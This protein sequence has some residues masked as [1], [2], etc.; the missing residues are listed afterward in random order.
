M[1]KAQEFMEGKRCC[2]RH[3]NKNLAHNKKRMPAEGDVK[4]NATDAL[5][6]LASCT[7]DCRSQVGLI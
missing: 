6:K 2:H 4:G 7:I 5:I 3:N 1:A